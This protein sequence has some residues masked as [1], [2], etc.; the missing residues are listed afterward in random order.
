MPMFVV[1]VACAVVSALLALHM[2]EI[3]RQKEPELKPYAWGYFVGWSGLTGGIAYGTSQIIAAF[4]AYGSRAE[5]LGMLG[6]FSIFFAIMHALVIRRN[7]WAWVAAIILQL[8]PILWIINGIYL[9]NRWTE[10]DDI[11]IRKGTNKAADAFKKLQLRSRIFITGSG[12][13]AA[14]VLLFVFLFDP[15]GVYILDSEWWLVI[16]IIA[17][18][19]AMVAAG[20]FL[21]TKIVSVDSISANASDSKGSNGGDFSKGR[22]LSHRRPE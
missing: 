17:F 22:D 18:P 1:L 21:Y 13:W 15:F 12:F 7:K 6:V 5:F 14:C 11:S 8:N 16:K 3:L 19:P 2:A 20:Y 9:R 4:D 10:F